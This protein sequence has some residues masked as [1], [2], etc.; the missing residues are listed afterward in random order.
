MKQTMLLKLAP[1]IE[2][3][4]AL[5][6]TMHAFNAACD[7]VAEIALSEKTANK[8]ALQKIV[9]GELRTT[10]KLAS[11]LAIRAISKAS[12]AYKRDKSI[13][14]TFRREGPL[15][16]D[17]RVMSF[18]GLT[19]VSLLTLCGRVLVAFIIG[20]FQQSRMDAI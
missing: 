9:Y 14:P 6:E 19:H 13:K 17:P 2:Q 10:Y 20:N 18:K 16:Y 7:Y 3:H 5:L 11:Q 4:Q 8:F 1:T 12:E 15:V